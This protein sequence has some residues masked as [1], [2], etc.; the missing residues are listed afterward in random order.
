MDINL[1]ITSEIQQEMKK[2]IEEAGGNEVFFR[3]ILDEEKRVSKIIVVARGN[4][5]SVPAILGRMKREE[6]IIHNHPSGYLY[7]SD[8]DIEVAT[9]YA[10]KMNGGFYI[11]NNKVD[12]VYVVIEP[13]NEENQKIDIVPYFEE[14]G[15]ISQN[16]KEFEFR[17][18]QLSMARHIQEGI[19]QEKKIIVEAGTGTGKTLAYLI[20]SIEWAVTNEKR[21]I[22]STNTINLQEQ[23]LNKD[24]P[25]LQKIMEKKFKYALVKGRGNYLC[26][27]KYFNVKSGKN[28]EILE[29]SPE[30]KNQLIEILNWGKETNTGDK[31]ELNIEPDYTVWELFQS[32]SDLCFSGCPH[33]EECFFFKARDEKK[34]ADILIANH[35]IFFSDLAI[36][37]EIGFSSDY[38][39]LPEY[40]MV[41]FDEAHNVE[42]V[43]RDYFS[44]EVSRY[45]FVKSMNK[46]LNVSKLKDENINSDIKLF[47]T[48]EKIKVIGQLKDIISIIEKTD[49]DE[50][51]ELEDIIDK[52][53]IKEHISLFNYGIKYFERL[54]EIFSKGQNGN[55]SVR[56]KKDDIATDG[57][58]K[59]LDDFRENFNLEFTRYLRTAKKIKDILSDVEDASGK[60]NEFLKYIE[61][62][63]SFYENFQF[64]NKF[65]DEEF[66]YWVEVN[67]RKNN[68]KL[69]ATP[70]KVD[71]ELSENLYDNLKQIIFT[72]A[73][74]SVSEN[75]E[76]FKKSIG[77][78]EET[79]DKI[80]KSPFDYDKQM[81]VY[82]PKGL[83]D[84][85]SREFADYI[86]EIIKVFLE[87]TGGRTFVLFTSYKML[88]YVYYSMREEL[89]ESGITLF[90]QGMYPRTKMVEIFKKSKAPVLFGTDSF[91][92]GVDVKG[93][94]LSSVII[95]KL[96]FK[97]PSDPVT[98]AIIE[99]FEQEGKNSFLEYQIPESIIKF[100]QGIGR[101]I[102]S[103]EDKGII[104]ILDNRVITKTYGKYFLESIPTKNISRIDVEDILRSGGKNEK[105]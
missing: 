5:Y 65:E 70:L 66:I 20:P 27:R 86:Q 90:I 88:N 30:Q 61:R 53:F 24:I 67:E 99:T 101:L 76:Y 85:N 36:K 56:I 74:L 11:I 82:I 103:K 21:V 32:E 41:V 55:I 73:T 22:I 47:E 102:R 43:A 42:K 91:W 23:L 13:Y 104:T 51:S 39:I 25:M 10:N 29:F 2:E 72:S 40:G 62:I 77:L 4:K 63:E 7:P 8:A 12:D 16:F 50:K 83:P 45:S 81:K 52:D 26:N 100:K 78:L 87:K 44:Y 33:R 60:V 59:L 80:I 98:E 96:P 6:V 105:I 71:M 38:S 57:F 89:E 17:E 34:R 84:P 14:E 49:F 28:K 19:N 95:V 68:S 46:I 1:R 75:F 35:H 69:V 15:I 93:D 3:G 64:I 97:V 9:V 37:K 31:S 18:E 58:L 92:E 48:N 54:I 94:Q 79:Y